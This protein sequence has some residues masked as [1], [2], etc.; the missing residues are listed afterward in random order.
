MLKTLNLETSLTKQS[1]IKIHIRYPTKQSPT[2]IKLSDFD[3][4][5]QLKII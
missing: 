3:L 2:T 4:L 5:L 1:N